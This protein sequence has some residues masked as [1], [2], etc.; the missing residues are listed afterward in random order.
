MEIL[1]HLGLGFGT[2][3]TFWN[4][5][6]CFVGAL[7]GTLV[8][9]LPGLGPLAT[10]AMLLPLTFSLE[11]VTALIMLSGIYYG[12]QYGGSTTA[13]LINLPGESSSV[14]TSIDGYQMARNGQA[15][16]ALSAAAIGSFVAGTIA[17]LVIAIAAPP[18]AALAL[19]FGPAEYF[20]LMVLGVVSAI[21][22]AHGSMLKAIIMVIL[23]LLLGLVGTDVETGA[24]RFTFDMPW[25]AEG[26]NFVAISMGIFGFGE[27]LVNLQNE[28]ARNVE[29]HKITRLILTREEL[30][31]IVGPI[32]RGTGLGSILGVL[33][34]GGAILSSFAAYSL[35]RSLS[36]RKSSFGK[37]AIEGVAAPEA[38]NNAGAQTSF[39]P[40]LTLGLPSNPLMALMIG[41]M[42]V[43]GITPGPNVINDEPALFWG[44]IASMWIGN[45]MLVILNLPLVGLWVRMLHI[46]YRAL[47]PA[48]VAITCIGVFSVNNTTFDVFAMA[49]F[50]IIGFI[51]TK[52]AFEPAPLL[53]GFVLGPMM[54]EYLR[55]ALLLSD[56]DF[57]VFATEPLSLCLLVAAA[58]LFGLVLFPKVRRR[59]E[60]VFV[61]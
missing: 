41:A 45:A 48:I 11:P 2:V 55:R 6:Y 12:A 35:E 14:V 4:I 44:L 43:H 46:P 61:E 42:V 36:K 22:L 31:R 20:S 27:I 39:I 8:G 58:L 24:Q 25:L 17:T 32:L 5:F 26:I 9:I 1:T 33:P 53:L 3:L 23:G 18:L 7:V 59:R 30:R 47:F 50:G 54:E 16:A 40:M 21:A 37:G 13:I 19:N 10:V 34:G 57:S 38:A 52:L 56:G 29:V 60:E 49:L 28:E 15:G 51:F